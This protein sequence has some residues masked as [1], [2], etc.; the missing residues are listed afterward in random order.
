MPSKNNWELW[1]HVRVDKSSNS[2]QTGNEWS[3]TIFLVAF[4]WVNY[5]RGHIEHSSKCGFEFPQELIITVIRNYLSFH[6]QYVSDRMLMR[7]RWRRQ[8]GLIW[9]PLPPQR[10]TLLRR[11]CG[12]QLRRGRGFKRLC[13]DD[14]MSYHQILSI[15]LLWRGFF[16][17]YLLGWLIP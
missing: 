7:M 16:F 4:F 1:R 10:K 11:Q 8:E 12:P 9:L 6:D 3:R 15:K 5:Q 17:N 2:K 13:S 14:L